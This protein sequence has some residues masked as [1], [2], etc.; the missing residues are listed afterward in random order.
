MDRV[1]RLREER[2]EV[3]LDQ[4]DLEDIA[5]EL[6]LT[7]ADLAA[8]REEAA[9]HRRRAEGFLRHDLVD[10]GVAELEEAAALAPTDLE[11]RLELAAALVRRGRRD[12]RERAR[13]L[14]MGVLD[15]DP[16]RETAFAVVAELRKPSRAFAPRP[17]AG[18]VPVRFEEPWLTLLVWQSE[19]SVYG[20]DGYYTLL[21]WIRNDGDQEL[22]ELTCDTVLRGGGREHVHE[23]SYYISAGAALRPGDTRRITTTIGAPLWDV[24]EVLL[25]VERAGLLPATTSYPASAVVELG[26]KVAKPPG[27][28]I[29]SRER[30]SQYA[31]RSGRHYL[32][33]E[34]E[35][36]G[37]RA[38]EDLRLDVVYYDEADEVLGVGDVWVQSGGFPPFLPGEVRVEDDWLELGQRPAR[39]EVLVREV[40]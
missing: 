40:K 24:E 7:E 4:R 5:R 10:E 6:G 13:E 28:E 15:V 9:D 32:V 39:Y 2:S 29:S 25:R 11:V 12:D 30:S 22:K 23:G 17:P 1:L 27:V 19:H 34:L 18:S 36:R 16:G 14:A 3:V 21:G 38:V 26:W 35:N 31:E 37:E 8:V 33:L 20:E